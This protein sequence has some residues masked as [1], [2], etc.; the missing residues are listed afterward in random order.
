MV[1]GTLEAN[2][3]LEERPDGRRLTGELSITSFR[4]VR[5]PLL[6]RALEVLALTGLRDVLTGRGMT[7]WAL[8][9]PFEE[10][11][12]II[13]IT[14]GRVAGPSIGMTGGGVVDLNGKSFDM[15]GTIIPFTGRTAS[16][17]RSR[18]WARC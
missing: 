3:R 2:G 12:G 4:L 14:G 15:R 1:G 18:C 16:S 8:R 7:F 9:L 5:A 17:A 10:S 6:A 13:E 11:D